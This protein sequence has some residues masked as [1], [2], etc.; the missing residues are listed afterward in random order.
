MRANQT[1]SPCLLVAL[2]AEKAFDRVSWLYLQKVLEKFGFTGT[3]LEHIL[4]LYKLPTAEI[5][6]NGL[7]SPSFT[8]S[9]G[10]RQGCPLSPLIFVL[11]MEPL[12]EAIRQHPQITGFQIGKSIYKISLFADDVIVTLTNPVKSLQALSELLSQ[13]AEISYYKTNTSKTEALPIWIPQNT[14]RNLKASYKFVWQQSAISYLG[15]KVGFSHSILYNM[16]FKSMLTKTE[17]YLK[18]WAFKEITWLG[19][20]SAV[21]TMLMP[22]ILYLFRTIPITVPNKFFTLLQ[23][24]ISRYIWKAKK[25]RI[26]TATL[27]RNKLQGGLGFP[28]FK[29]YYQAAHLNF[30][31]HVFTTSTQPQWVLQEKELS[32]PTSL[33]LD[34]LIWIPP[35]LRIK[36]IILFPT[37]Q[38]S[39]KVWDLYMHSDPLNQ[40]LHPK[41]PLSAFKGV[42]PNFNS[43]PWSQAGMTLWSDI[44]INNR[45]PTFEALRRKWPIPTKSFYIY[46]QLASFHRANFYCVPKQLSTI[47]QKL[48]SSIMSG[49]RISHFYSNINDQLPNSPNTP[50]T[51]WNKELNSEIDP[52]DWNSA[53]ALITASTKSA[54]LLEPSIKLMYRWYLV[55]TRLYKIYPLTSSKECWR[56]CAQEGTHTHI[57][58]DC[59]KIVPFWTQVFDLINKVIDTPIPKIP[60]IALLNLELDLL[61]YTQKTLVVHFLETARLLI[62]QRWKTDTIPDMTAMVNL[63][64]LTEKLEFFDSRNRNSVSS[65]HKKWSSWE[66]YKAC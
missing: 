36:S 32:T 57:W 16:N 2:D 15:I 34:E 66:N 24:L 17:Q 45:F 43:D 37:L 29:K 1:K 20:L 12:A 56:G 54:R 55:P 49:A 9:N 42:I 60:T 48:T 18:T 27:S 3:F 21:K 30:I 19:R 22:K 40:G 4:T 38:A 13:F 52:I 62:A 33:H 26:L 23:K 39:L 53:F 59:L 10:T 6:A 14:L 35:K 51:A 8:L 44:L 61:K 41:F 65:H 64:D 28:N 50:L 11:L 25:P 63:L 47:Q 46:L 58:W 31:Q 5:R 7:K